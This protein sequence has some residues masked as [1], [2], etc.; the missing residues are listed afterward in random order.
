M[1]FPLTVVSWEIAVALQKG[2]RKEIRRSELT[3]TAVRSASHVR[4]PSANAACTS[5]ALTWCH[6]ADRTAPVTCA[7]LTF[8]RR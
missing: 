2:H 8:P 3:I 4:S 6:T 7:S 1:D 5:A